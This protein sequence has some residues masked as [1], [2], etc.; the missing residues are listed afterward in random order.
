ME[1]DNTPI[2]TAALARWTPIVIAL[3]GIVVSAVWIAASTQSDL[4]TI[5]A[6]ILAQKTEIEIRLQSDERQIASNT[7]HV[8]ATDRDVSGINRRLDVVVTILERLERA[9]HKEDRTEQKGN[10]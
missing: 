8:E 3:G 1:A 5:R 10:E 2:T 7:T 6:S 4:S 9:S